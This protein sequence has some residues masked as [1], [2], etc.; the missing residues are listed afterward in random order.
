VENFKPQKTK[1]IISTNDK[2]N[3][4]SVK[5]KKALVHNNLNIYSVENRS[6]ISWQDE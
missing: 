3:Q 4:K 1:S 5:P 6:V 2:K